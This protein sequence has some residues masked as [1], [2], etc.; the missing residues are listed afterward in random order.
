VV[1]IDRTTKR[2]VWQYGHDSVAGRALG[3]LHTPDGLDLVR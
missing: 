3:Y 1:I 2:I